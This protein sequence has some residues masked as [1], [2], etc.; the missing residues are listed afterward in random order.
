MA[1]RIVHNAKSNREHSLRLPGARFWTLLYLVTVSVQSPCELRNC[2]T[3]SSNGGS[4]VLYL[5]RSLVFAKS[6][7]LTSWL[8]ALAE[9]PD[10]YGPII[11]RV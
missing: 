8:N 7:A 1:H 5:F 6:L 10:A 2:R 9:V 11:A 3:A 4:I